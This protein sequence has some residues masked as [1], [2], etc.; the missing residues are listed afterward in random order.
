MFFRT[1]QPFFVLFQ[2]KPALQ[3]A[4][5]PGPHEF[6]TAGGVPERLPK[7]P[8][9]ERDPVPLRRCGEGSGGHSAVR[10]RT[11][12]QGQECVALSL[13]ILFIRFIYYR[14]DSYITE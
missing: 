4:D 12:K 5:P 9:P 6:R 7:G 3:T 14:L 13:H 2:D 1:N 10:T 11:G 8:P